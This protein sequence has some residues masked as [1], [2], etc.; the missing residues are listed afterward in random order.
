MS[1]YRGKFTSSADNFSADF[2]A[3]ENLVDI[4]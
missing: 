4:N 3:A 1:P 2:A